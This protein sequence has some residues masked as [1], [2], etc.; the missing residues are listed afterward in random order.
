MP[1]SW[2]NSALGDA[3][4]L[5]VKCASSP[6]DAL[7]GNQGIVAVLLCFQGCIDGEP[8]GINAGFEFRMAI[9][10]H[11]YGPPAIRG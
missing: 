4:Y 5:R 9:G 3:L 8:D 11:L 7:D 1:L 10:A 6:I 2:A